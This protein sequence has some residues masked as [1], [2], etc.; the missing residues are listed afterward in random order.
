MLTKKDNIE[1]L[2]YLEP[3]GDLC[4][5]ECVGCSMQ[6][7]GSL[8]LIDLIRIRTQPKMKCKVCDGNDWVFNGEVFEGMN[9]WKCPDCGNRQADESKDIIKKED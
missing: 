3:Y 7:Q 8:C 5:G 6:D 2:K 9:V 1:I 4:D